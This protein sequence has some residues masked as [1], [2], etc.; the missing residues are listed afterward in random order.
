MHIDFSHRS[1]PVCGGTNN[2]PVLTDL[3]RREGFLVWATLVRCQNCGVR[4]LNPA[5]D[6]ASLAK[7]YRDGSVDPVMLNPAKEQPVSRTHA[8]VSR[9]RSAFIAI[10]QIYSWLQTNFM[11]LLFAKA[12][13]WRHAE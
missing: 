4:Y 3:N 12:T 1:C 5:P 13:F 11:S 10:G 6:A 9:R 7:L 2:E 8:P